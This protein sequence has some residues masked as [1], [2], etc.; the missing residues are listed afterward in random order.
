[1]FHKMSKYGKGDCLQPN[2][3]QTMNEVILAVTAE[4]NHL[5]YF[6]FLQ[7]YK[8]NIKKMI[9]H[10]FKTYW[11]S[12]VIVSLH[13]NAYIIPDVWFTTKVTKS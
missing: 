13:S 3:W 8:K 9:T 10:F 11:T 5:I 6:N 1:M 4:G 2:L 12:I 7:N